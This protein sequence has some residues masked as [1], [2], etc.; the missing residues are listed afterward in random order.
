MEQNVFKTYDDG[1]A[2]SIGTCNISDL[3]NVLVA[4]C[5]KNDTDTIRLY[6]IEDFINELI[7]KI[8][9]RAAEQEFL[10]IDYLFSK[11]SFLGLTPDLAKSYIILK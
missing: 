10:W 2:V 1:M 9:E 7:P 11:G 6:G 8:Y 5:Y 3:P 4:S